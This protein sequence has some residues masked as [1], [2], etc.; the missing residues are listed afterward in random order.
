MCH[1]QAC[2]NI[3][4]EVTCLELVEDELTLDD[5][6]ALTWRLTFTHVDKFSTLV[7]SI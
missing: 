7:G 4:Y 5:S 2:G 3:F 1:A 6:Y